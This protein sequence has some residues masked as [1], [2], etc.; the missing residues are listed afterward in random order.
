MKRRFR[1][2]EETTLYKFSGT[3]IL[4][5][6]DYEDGETI[7]RKH[8]YEINESARNIKGLINEINISCNHVFSKDLSDWG[9]STTM[10]DRS[11]IWTDATVT[12]G[13][14]TPTEEEIKKWKKR[15]FKL[16][17]AHIQG[18]ICK[19]NTTDLTE[20]EFVE[21]GFELE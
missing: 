6:D 4:A 11:E 5:E 9:A 3:V 1:E 21:L 14:E 8:Y 7:E 13:L 2:S 15:R 17:N 19:I 16:Y 20:E 18:H 10:N 12:A